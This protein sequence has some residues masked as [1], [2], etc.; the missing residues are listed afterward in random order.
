MVKRTTTNTDP[1]LSRHVLGIFFGMDSNHRIQD[2][3][4]VDA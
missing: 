2:E 1:Y 4:R 3:P